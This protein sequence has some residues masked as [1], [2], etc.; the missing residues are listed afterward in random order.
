MKSASVRSALKNSLVSPSVRE[1]ITLRLAEFSLPVAVTITLEGPDD[2]RHKPD[3][4]R[5]INSQGAAM[6]DRMRTVL[7]V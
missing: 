1:E 4:G 7:S 3:L 2:R 5:A 6:I